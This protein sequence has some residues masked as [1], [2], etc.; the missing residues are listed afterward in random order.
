MIIN[1]KDNRIVAKKFIDLFIGDFFMYN[2]TIYI[3]VHNFYVR[4]SPEN[5]YYNSIDINGNFYDF[6]PSDVLVSPIKKITLTV[7]E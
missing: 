1:V 5:I 2:G 4:S 3:K 7:E 6:C